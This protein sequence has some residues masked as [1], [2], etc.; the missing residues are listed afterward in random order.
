M[1]DNLKTIPHKTLWLTGIF[2]FAFLIRVIYSFQH[3]P[4]LAYSGGGDSGFYLQVGRDLV[5]GLDYSGIPIPVPPVYLLIVGIPQHILSPARTIYVLWLFQSFS[6]AL[7]CLFAFRIG[8]QL[9]N[10][11]RVGLVASIALATSISLILEAGIIQTEAVYIAFLLLAFWLYIDGFMNENNSQLR[12]HLS[13]YLAGGVLGFAALTRPVLMLFPAGIAIHML[14]IGRWKV[15]FPFLV[16]YAF[17]FFSWTAYTSLYYDWTV[18]GSNQLFP[19][20]WRG[21]VEG[22]G[23]PQQNDELLGEQ[24][25]LEQTGDIITNNLAD[26]AQRRITELASAYLQPHGTLSLGSESLK[27]LAIDWVRSGF[28]GDIFLAMLTSE[29]FIWKVLIYIWHYVALIAGL[30]GMWLTRHQWRISLV[31]VGYILYTTLLHLVALAI[32]RYIFPTF[33]FFWIFAAVTLLHLWD[34]LRGKTK[35]AGTNPPQESM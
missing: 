22:D 32:P 10:D 31:L 5:G 28:S 16:A 11:E 14:M 17:I 33:P 30:I 34:L 25:A 19:A 13:L 4:L 2:L 7:S 3:D 27:A 35:E 26:F 20:I 24:T 8:T 21:A 9:T 23:S 1:G 15:I 6:L 12:K 29:Q 18:I